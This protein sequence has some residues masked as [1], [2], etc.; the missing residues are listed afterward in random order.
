M[1]TQYK[2]IKS[3]TKSNNGI[4][5]DRLPLVKNSLTT[6][7]YVSNA[8]NTTSVNSS[9]KEFHVYSGQSWITGEHV[10]DNT[11]S[12]LITLSPDSQ[13]SDFIS[14]DIYKQLEKLKLTA[15]NYRI[16]VNFF[17]NLIGSYNRQDLVV[18]EI[19]PDRTEVKLRAI[20]SSQSTKTQLANFITT[21]NQTANTILDGNGNR[22]TNKFIPY[23]LNFSR[24]KCYL[25]IN[26]VV[27]DNFLYVKLLEPLPNDIL[28]DYKCWVA[29][30]T[31]QPY[32]DHINILPKAS[33]QSNNNK[34][35]SPNFEAITVHNVSADTGYKTWSDLL[36]VSTPTSQQLIDS[37]F[38]G[39][40]A[41]M[42]LNIDFRDF[43]NFVFYS[44]A[45]ERVANFR[46]K[47]QLLE[48]YT[49]QSA[50]IALITN[51]T[52]ATTNAIDIKT[53]RDNLIG[54]FDAFENYLYYETGSRLTTHNIPLEYPNVADVTGSYISPAPKI[55]NIQY[56]VS[57]SQFM[58]WYNA[59][60]ATASMYDVKNLNALRN[61]VPLHIQNSDNSIN[62]QLFA[63][64][65]GHHFDILY[66]YI[67][68]MSKIHKRDEN[69]KTGMPNELLYS[70][71]QQFGWNL[72]DGRQSDDLWKY[73]F[74]L[75]TNGAPITGSNSVMNQSTGGK[76]LTYATWRRI[77]NNLPLLL[78]TNGTKRSIYALMSFIIKII[79]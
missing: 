57:S 29:Q 3:I 23:I 33:T 78:K 51:S 39:S 68:H 28:I 6:Y 38:S 45:A 4:S 15:G 72:A 35:S 2:N 54:G 60:H 40:L 27:V 21:V 52:V 47:M 24:N 31:R 74:G 30:E 5:A 75:D 64:M 53:K 58:G 55:N 69:P 48:Q 56:S 46:Y 20:D 34:F 18:D 8:T 22:I 12:R 41:G 11:L 61:T 65:L 7:T 17:K 26:S 49:A 25:F 76:D 37:Y 50:S 10:V 71:A 67:N 43:N 77:V 79:T 59:L 32:L 63:D 73:V 44:S 9:V 70:V 1:L 16:V 19:S 13:T 62:V 36:S 42:Q 66:T 14:I